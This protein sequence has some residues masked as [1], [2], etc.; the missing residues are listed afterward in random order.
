MVVGKRREN[1]IFL[2]DSSDDFRY[3]LGEVPHMEPRKRTKKTLKEV[4]IEHDVDNEDYSQYEFYHVYAVKRTFTK[5][6]FKQCNMLSCYFRNCSFNDCDFTGAIVK[7]SKLKGAFFNNCKFEYSIWE[8]TLL[9]EEFLDACLPS[10]ENLARDLVRSLRVNY[11]QIG[12]YDAVNKA[13]SIEVR[14]TGDHLYNATYSKQAYYRDKY[15][16]WSRIHM[17][18]RHAS[19]KSLQ[20]LWGNGESFLRVGMWCIVS[21]ALIALLL[22]MNYPEY[23]LKNLSTA[24]AVFWGLRSDCEVS[25]AYSLPSAFIRYFYLAFLWPFWSRDCPDDET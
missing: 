13:A 21:M 2:C 4:D 8:R 22:Q 18:L 16:G 15:K 5:V 23:G 19:W 14:L 6:S 3:D 10:Q 12:N 9:D 1:G 20:L 17:G 7:D 24:S 25:L 11:A